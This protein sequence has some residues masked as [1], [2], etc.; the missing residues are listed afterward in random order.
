MQGAPRLGWLLAGALD[1]RPGVGE[2]GLQ[3]HILVVG[4]VPRDFGSSENTGGG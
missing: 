3:G 1:P 2:V 4:I